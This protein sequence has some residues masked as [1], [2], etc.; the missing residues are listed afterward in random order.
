MSRP[1]LPLVVSAA[2][3][4]PPLSSEKPAVQMDSCTRVITDASPALAALLGCSLAG[5]IG[6]TLS[7]LWMPRERF[8]LMRRFEDV[9]LLGRDRFGAVA[10]S[11]VDAEPVW[12][13]IDARFLY[14]G[15]QRIEATLTPIRLAGKTAVL[16]L[17]PAERRANGRPLA[18]GADRPS[19]CGNTS[20][21]IRVAPGPDTQAGSPFSAAPVVVSV[22]HA[23]AMAWGIYSGHPTTA[24]SNER[25][26][27]PR[28]PC[29]TWDPGPLPAPLSHAGDPSLVMSALQTC[30]AA[31][32]RIGHDGCVADA[33]AH[34]EAVVGRPIGAVR[35]QSVHALLRLSEAAGSALD[36]AR[37]N[38]ERQT[39]LA[40]V[41]EARQVVVEW[42][43]DGSAGG[44]YAVLVDGAPEVEQ[45]ADIRFKSQLISLVAH[46]LR[47]SVAAVTCGLRM[48]VDDLAPDHPQHTTAEQSLA[49]CQRVNRILEDVLAASRPGNLIEVELDLDTVIH[50]TLDRYR[51]RASARSIEV[52][53]ELSSGA[54]VL[55]DLSGL[56]RA[57]GNL[58][59]NALDA[60]AS[61]G[62]IAVVT[63]REDR[64]VPGVVVSV[65][66]TGVGIKP[67]T[68]PNVFEPYVTA[69]KGGT[70]LGLAI[71]RQIVLD[72]RG[73]IDFETKEGCGTTFRVWLPRIPAAV[74]GGA[75]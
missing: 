46:D 24:S 37:R 1:C 63:S 39:V 64:G 66:D 7:D 30:G 35:G 58:I 26:V 14:R 50:E 36:A 12:V 57:L 54:R 21:A 3:R 8:A 74:D 29:P 49:E 51:A 13:E 5:L 6:R 40:T 73:Q 19:P 15:G 2:R 9:V 48:L 72:H 20:A 33:T 32:L 4:F 61:Y 44:G 16:R 43:P 34:V 41:A 23:P 52:A 55:G 38:A 59:E 62:R 45:T 17:S 65:A 53:D 47:N 69:K 10:L 31:A 25:I 68:R 56:E 67:E 71:T 22:T 18:T 28:V 60:T 42:L 70:G 27:P 11:R 75:S